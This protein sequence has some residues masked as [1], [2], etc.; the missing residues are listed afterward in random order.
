[1]LL[2]QLTLAEP[3][4][5][6]GQTVTQ[7]WVNANYIQSMIRAANST[8]IEFSKKTPHTIFREMPEEIAILANQ[9]L[10]KLSAVD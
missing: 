9:A 10:K 2:I 6:H 8:I 5:L 3:I 4:R 7:I 1:M